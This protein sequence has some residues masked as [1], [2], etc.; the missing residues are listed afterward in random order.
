[1]NV[2]AVETVELKL[3]KLRYKFWTK[4]D[5][6]PQTSYWISENCSVLKFALLNANIYALFT[7]R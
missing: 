2:G 1:M 4:E 6:I 3:A 5:E 7:K